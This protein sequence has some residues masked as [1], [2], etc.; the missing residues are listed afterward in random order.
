M[1]RTN[2][3]LTLSFYKGLAVLLLS[4]F[5]VL[6]SASAQAQCACKGHINVSVG[7]NCSATLTAAEMLADG[8][9]CAGA[10]SVVSIMKTPTGGVLAT[11]TGSATLVDATLYLGKTLYGKVSD[12]TPNGNSCWGTIKI[13][14]KLAPTIDCPGDVTMTCYQLASFAP[15]VTE[16]CSHYRVNLVNETVKVNDCKESTDLPDNVLKVITRQYQAVD[17]SGNKS[18]ICDMTITVVGLPALTQP[19]LTKP[20]NLMKPIHI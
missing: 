1:R 12:G 20:L 6:N 10:S 5:S 16:N 7:A 19:Y 4:F 11:G 14:D 13:E 9:S 2:S 8:S 18:P 15:V 17:E 3:T